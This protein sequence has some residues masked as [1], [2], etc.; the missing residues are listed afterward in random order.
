MAPTPPAAPET[1]DGGASLGPGARWASRPGGG[2]AAVV[3]G[4]VLWGT[5]GLA[6]SVIAD[7]GLP[8]AVVAAYRLTVGGGALLLVLGLAGRLRGIPRSAA[9]LRRVLLTAVLAAVYQATYFLAVERSSV[10]VATVVALG[11][12]PVIVAT[13]TAVLARRLPSR[14]TTAAVGLAV[15]GLV[16]LV[17]LSRTGADPAGGA[18]LAL[19]AAAAFAVL[20]MVN[21]TGVPGLDPVLL[22]A[23]GFSG[24]GLLLLPVVLLGGA[25]LAP[26]EPSTWWLVLYLGV[27]PT[28]LAYAAY[29][30]GLRTVPATVAS[31]VALLEPLTA[32]LAAAFLL[33]ERLGPGGVVGGVLLATATVVVAPRR[34][35]PAAAP[36]RRRAAA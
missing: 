16:L 7:G 3:V 19:V 32:A 6:G 35:R 26:S 12:A 2:F 27:V 29:F 36:R 28:A 4:A 23:L 8:M 1:A 10:S 33:G 22:T 15:V 13:V 25:A 11:A 21:R 30:T 34:R 24:G 18:G 31:L 20:T 14:R 17:G 5:G 9:L